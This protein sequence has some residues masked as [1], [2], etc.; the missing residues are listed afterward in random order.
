MAAETSPAE[1]QAERARLEV[2]ALDACEARGH[3]MHA[4]RPN[5]WRRSSCSSACCARCGRSVQVNAKPAPNE[6][7]I[8]GEA[9][10]LNCST[11]RGH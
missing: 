2:E 5:E 10:A 6:I 9:V 7:D 11:E 4:F 1:M 8:G 3:L